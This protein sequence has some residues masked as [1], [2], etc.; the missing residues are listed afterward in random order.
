ME[1]EAFEDAI[2]TPTVDGRKYTKVEKPEELLQF[3]NCMVKVKKREGYGRMKCL[4][5][6]ILNHIDPQLRY[7]YIRSIATHKCFCMQIPMCEFWVL[8][9]RDEDAEIR[10]WQ[11]VLKVVFE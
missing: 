1:E 2:N 4:S 3:K 6:G 9:P 10:A 5:G 8:P 11:E 7:V